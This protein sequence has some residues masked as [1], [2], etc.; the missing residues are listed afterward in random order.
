[1]RAHHRGIRLCQEPSPR[2]PGLAGAMFCPGAVL[3]PERSAAHLRG[4]FTVAW[5]GCVLSACSWAALT[6][7]ATLNLES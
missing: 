5:P 2:S 7:T 1:M 6:L 4:A 3:Q